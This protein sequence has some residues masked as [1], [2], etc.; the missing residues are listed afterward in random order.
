MEQKTSEAHSPG[1]PARDIVKKGSVI[2]LITLISRPLGYIREAIQAYLFGATLLVDAFIVA[3]NFPE[4][5]QTL[6]FSGAT[7]AFLIPVCTRY[8]HDRSEY[9]RI[10]STFINLS[11]MITFFV[12]VVFFLFSAVITGMIAPGFSPDAKEITRGLFIIMIP[13]I[14]LHTLLSVM[15]AFL[16]AK[17]HFAAPEMSGILWNIAFIVAALTLKDRFGIY[18]L[19]IGVTAGSFL[20]II[21]Q[22]PYLRKLGIRYSFSL[23]FSHPSFSEARS[24]FLGALIATSIVPINSFI[25]RIIASYLPQGEVASLSYAFRIFILP[26]SLFAVPVYTVTFSKVSRFYHNRDWRGISAHID[27]S[28]IL[29]CITLIPSTILLCSV[30]DICTKILY[31]RGAF[32][33]YETHI[34]NRALFGYSIGLIFYALSISLVRIFNALHDMK[35]PALVGITSIFLNAVLA[36]L[37]M[38]PFK[39]LGISLATSIVSL[40]NFAFLYVLLRKKIEY[41]MTKRTVRDIIKT[42][43]AGITLTLAIALARHFFANDYAILFSCVLFTATIY[44]LFFKDYY[45]SLLKK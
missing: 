41:R 35:T 21:M 10:Y 34:T 25:G 44:G 22:Y 31:E 32:G 2:T 24:L 19:A 9:S 5:I 29:L 15:K 36:S 33:S 8:L 39:N 28:I 20:Q 11:L 45:R 13:V 3:F 42:L 38:V 4:L 27:S 37:L 6:F 18:S 16:N 43:V 1:N 14:S 23:D 17:E 30:G 40:Y 12:S 7:S 26:F